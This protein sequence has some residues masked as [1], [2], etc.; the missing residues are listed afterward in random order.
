MRLSLLLAALLSVVPF[1]SAEAAD[2]QSFERGSWAKLREAHAGQPTVIHF[3]G[4]TCGPCLVELPHW[5]ALQAARPDLRLVLIAADPLPQ[6]PER[7]AATLAKAGLDKAESW[8]FTDRFYERLRY[9][10]DPAWAGELPRTMMIDRNG[11]ATVLPG[12]ADLA[13]VR[14]WLGAQS[15]S[16]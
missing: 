9:E 8:S 3:W 6:D 11:K 2:P 15:K 10:I 13:Q 7:L 4:L 16:H 12:V 5:G 14:Q 1:W